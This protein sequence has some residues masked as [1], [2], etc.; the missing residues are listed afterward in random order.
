MGAWLRR[1]GRSI[2][3]T[4]GGP[5]KPGSWGASTH[6]GNSL[7]LHVFQ[8]PGEDLVLPPIHTTI[9]STRVLTGGNARVKQT[10]GSV[11]VTLPKK[12][13]REIDTLIEIKLDGPAGDIPPVSVSSRSKTG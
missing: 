9:V 6:S 3:A 13:R 7:Y 8:W 5:F 12:D 2:Y 10:A 4:R 11:V 1:Y